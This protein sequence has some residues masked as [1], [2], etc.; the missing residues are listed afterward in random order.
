MQA[1]VFAACIVPAVIATTT[2]AVH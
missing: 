1:A 2:T